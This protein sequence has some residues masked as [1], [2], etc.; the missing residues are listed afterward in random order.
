MWQY[1]AEPQGVHAARHHQAALALVGPKRRLGAS[2]VREVGHKWWRCVESHPILADCNKPD[3]M[4]RQETQG[5]VADCRAWTEQ[6][7]R[8]RLMWQAIAPGR[9]RAAAG[10]G[11]SET[12]IFDCQMPAVERDQAMAIGMWQACGFKPKSSDQHSP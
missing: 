3:A 11:K 4:P 10:A 2:K 12:S 5:V 1:L 9:S 8:N 7:Q 6:N